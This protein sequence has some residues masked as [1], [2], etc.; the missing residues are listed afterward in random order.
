MV[1]FFI[2]RG[3]YHCSTTQF[4]I[5][6]S[7]NF[8]QQTT[9]RLQQNEQTFSRQCWPEPGMCFTFIGLCTSRQSQKAVTM[10]TKSAQTP[11]I[12]CM[13]YVDYANELICI[14]RTFE[15][16]ESKPQSLATSHGSCQIT[17]CYNQTA[18]TQDFMVARLQLSFLAGDIS[19][20]CPRSIYSLSF[21]LLLIASIF[22]A[23]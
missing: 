19:R 8:L 4:H 7:K 15:Y 18:T 22:D 11:C 10:F 16:M 23:P 2:F 14:P 6:C 9:Q 5:T 3:G 17:V 12:T 1:I 13:H 20:C 21:P